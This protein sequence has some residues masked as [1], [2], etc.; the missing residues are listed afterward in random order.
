M[1]PEWVSF[2]YDQQLSFNFYIAVVI[3]EKELQQIEI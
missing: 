2:R 3:L 1:M